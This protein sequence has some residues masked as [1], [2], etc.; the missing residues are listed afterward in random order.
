M[1]ETINDFEDVFL[2]NFTV[3]SVDRTKEQYFTP[4]NGYPALCEDPTTYD[5]DTAGLG[6]NFKDGSFKFSFVYYEQIPS[7]DDVD[8]TSFLDK[9][10]EIA[11]ELTTS[12][13]LNAKYNFNVSVNF[14]KKKRYD[15]EDFKAIFT[16]SGEV[17]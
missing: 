10:K 9:V 16:I 14:P 5:P 1:N 2:D 12:S 6:K 11:K 15:N 3:N 8:M 4:S 13:K 7:D 17:I